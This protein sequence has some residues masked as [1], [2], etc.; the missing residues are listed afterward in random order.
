MLCKRSITSFER[1]GGKTGNE[2]GEKEA[3]GGEGVSASRIGEKKNSE[4]RIG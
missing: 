3:K 1:Q 2:R 4:G